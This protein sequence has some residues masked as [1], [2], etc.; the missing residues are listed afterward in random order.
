MR[1]HSTRAVVGGPY[2][3]STGA[4]WEKFPHIARY[5]TSYLLGWTTSDNP[6]A[7]FTTPTHF[8]LAEIGSNGAV[9]RGPTEITSVASFSYGSTWA[10]VENTGDVVWPHRR[11]ATTIDIVRV[12]R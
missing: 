1:P 7:D 2:W 3:I 5:G 9:L 8:W 6:S 4:G 12:A 10:T 11:N